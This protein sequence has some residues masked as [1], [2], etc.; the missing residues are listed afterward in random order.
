M[1]HV[2]VT[3]N[4]SLSFCGRGF[5]V[6]K[7]AKIENTSFDWRG[8]EVGYFSR[9][10]QWLPCD[11]TI[12][13]EG[14]AKIESYINNLHPEKHSDLY[15][16]IEGLVQKSLPAWDL[17]YCWVRKYSVLRLTKTTR[18]VGDGVPVPDI[19]PEVHEEEIGGEKIPSDGQPDTV[20][21]PEV[22][23]PASGSEG[24]E[25]EESEESD[26]S[27]DSLDSDDEEYDSEDDVACDPS[28]YFK[29][30]SKDVKHS[31]FF[32]NVPRIQVIVKLANIQLTPENPSYDGGSW[33]IEGQLN[34]HIVAT[35]LFYYDSSN[36]TDSYLAFRTEANKENLSERI[37]YEQYDWDSIEKIFALD[38]GFHTMQD[39]GSVL[40]RS[41]RALFFPN[42]CQH[43]VQPFE[44]ED[45]TK[46]GHRKIVALFL[47][48][49]AISVIST[50]NIP[51]QQKHWFANGESQAASGDNL[52]VS[53]LISMREA[54]RVRKKLMA[55]RTVM[56]ENEEQ[57]MNHVEWSF[58][59]H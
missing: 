4:E 16:I 17:I 26:G 40:T 7:P 13:D 56:Q 38:A 43:K 27:D 50:S 49:P 23:E 52:N 19:V 5:R 3:L 35:A 51:P 1:R 28:P 29:V 39:I 46:N 47:V 41:G 11:V 32:D 25:E 59:E 57:E 20:T 18:K 45:D 54:K 33:H 36:I 44:L 12:D 14:N 24:D 15:P 37:D 53:N 6:P 2:R 10:F 22:I 21:T 8:R 31:G 55:E 48:D 9:K 30:S 34:E 58:C 42:L